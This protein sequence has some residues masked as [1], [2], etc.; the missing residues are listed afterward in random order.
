MRFAAA[1]VRLALLIGLGA[2]AAC[3]PANHY[4]APPPATVGVAQ[5]EQRTITR[6]LDTT[7][8]TTAINSVDL[9]ARVQG[10]LQAQ[11]YKDGAF[12]TKG[13]NLFTIEPL[14]YQAKLQQAQAQEAA[15]QAQLVQA[16]A[17]YNRQASLGQ[18]SF[19]S[20]SQVDQALATRNT[21]RANLLGAQA[22][23]QLA[24]I[25]Y[26]YTRVTAPFDGI[27]TAH[28]VSVGEVVGGNE[29][30][31]LATIVQLAPIYVNF[32]ISEQDVQRI[33][34]AMAAKGITREHAWPSAGRGRLADRDR[35]SACRHA[36]LR[37]A[38]GRCGDRHAG[39]ARGVRQRGP[40][41]AAGEFRARPGA[42]AARR[43]RAAGAGRRTGRRPGRALRA[44]GR[45]G[46]RR[47]ATPRADRRADGRD[48]GDR[49]RIEARRPRG[50]GGRAARDPRREGRARS[51]K[52][53]PPCRPRRIERRA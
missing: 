26:T 7:G 43:R 29:M 45:A 17:D 20:Q 15:A 11:T 5:P 1:T 42:V 10:F 30:T 40:R 37:G 24:A 27:V 48:A 47:G 34:A 39:G 3:K 50:G 6:Y 31:K 22:N 35:I 52:P 16:D 9:V 4:A 19:S 33:R 14:P 25:N 44:G 28:L 49:E 8:T 21:D 36:R 13:T 51:C 53:P 18:S 32:S 46:R 38:D 2:L 12:V 23:T 41:A